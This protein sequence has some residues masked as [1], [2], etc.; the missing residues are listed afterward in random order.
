MRGSDPP[1][2]T[3]LFDTNTDPTEQHDLSASHPE[4]LAELQA[5]LA[6]HMAEQEPSAWPSQGSFAINVDKDLS[7][8][9]APDDEYIYWSN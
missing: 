3:W 5:A 1:G 7:V 6:A 8:P 4:K 2:R 9:D